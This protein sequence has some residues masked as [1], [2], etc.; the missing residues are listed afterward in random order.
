MGAER[1]S[2]IG[3]SFK[4]TNEDDVIKFNSYTH[5]RKTHRLVFSCTKNMSTILW[6]RMEK[7][8][9]SSPVK[10]SFKA[11]SYSKK[12]EGNGNPLQCSCLENPRDRGAWWASVYG[13]AQSR[14]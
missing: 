3:Q 11:F 1:Q 4:Q 10:K 6:T 8:T 9:I 12:G 13:V 2:L 7:N 5:D 14:T